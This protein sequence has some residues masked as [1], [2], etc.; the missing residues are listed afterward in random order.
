MKIGIF[1]YIT[2]IPKDSQLKYIFII[3]FALFF[4]TTVF[5]FKTP[6]IAGL[7]IGIAI[8]LFMQDKLNT[9]KHLVRGSK[10]D[11]PGPLKQRDLVDDPKS[12][13]KDADIINLL[14]N[15]ADFQAYNPAAFEQMI[16]AIDN[17]L[18]L[19]DD[20]VKFN[21]I[22][23][24]DD[25][26]GQLRRGASACGENLQVADRFIA[27][28]MN[29]YHSL[30]V[31][32]PSNLAIDLKFQNNQNRLHLLLRRHRDDMFR[33]CKKLYKYTGYHTQRKVIS[34]S[35]PKGVNPRAGPFDFYN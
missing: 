27:D 10:K 31:A 16:K 15:V 4:T 24:S 32:L 8:V 34:N 19:H 35:G 18:K 17:V 33:L 2:K 13:H 22:N 23:N 25:P 29:H 7:L 14:F 21:G 30:I 1:D 5:L 28:A 11:R 6:H 9:I 3:A 12:L 20:L 26:A